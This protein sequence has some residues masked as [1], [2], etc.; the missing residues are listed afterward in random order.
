MI[1]NP[2]EI[3]CRPAFAII[4]TYDRSTGGR[5]AAGKGRVTES[6]KPPEEIEVTTREVSCDGGGGASGHP[7]VFLNMGE[8]DSID[9]P[10][11]GRRFG[12]K[13]GAGAAAAH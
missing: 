3:D 4:R 6:M 5:K 12:L 11:C 1:G 13:E 8:T 9:C 10:Y 2:S 7:R